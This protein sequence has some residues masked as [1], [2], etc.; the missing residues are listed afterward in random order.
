[1]KAIAYCGLA[2]CVCSENEHC[3]G[4]QDGG[5]ESHGWCK[6]YNCCKEKGLHGCW[7]CADFPCMGGMLDNLRIRAFAAF[8]KRYGTDEL[9]KCLLRNK[10]NGIVYHYDGQL[11]GDYDTGTGEEEI[12]TMIK[13]GRTK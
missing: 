12:I 11:T 8:A 7:E 5:C 4:C 1:M 9:E 3:A 6:H 10:E 13:T 2:C